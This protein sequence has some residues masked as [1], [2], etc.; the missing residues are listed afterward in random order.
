MFSSAVSV[1]LKV[2]EEMSQPLGHSQFRL[3]NIST[4]VSRYQQQL[5]QVQEALNTAESHNNHSERLLEDIQINL[6]QLA[7]SLL[8]KAAFI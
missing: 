4:T 6:R 8:L 5:L 1:L 3:E 7:V 2:Q